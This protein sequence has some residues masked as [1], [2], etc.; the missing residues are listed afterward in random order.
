MSCSVLNY[1]NRNVKWDSAK[2]AFFPGLT[3]LS[4]GMRYNSAKNMTYIPNEGV[5]MYGDTDPWALKGS[6]CN[7]MDIMIT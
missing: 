6:N 3:I 5:D 1:F 4:D 7:T 2:L